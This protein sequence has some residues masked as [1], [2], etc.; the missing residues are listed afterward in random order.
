MRMS[1]LILTVVAAAW[2]AHVLAADVYVCKTNGK[3]MYSDK[4]C[5][6][7]QIVRSFDDNPAPAPG[8]I[9]DISEHIAWSADIR[10]TLHKVAAPTEQATI[11]RAPLR[12]SANPPKMKANYEPGV[13]PPE[14][15][16]TQGMESGIKV[17]AS[18]CGGA[19]CR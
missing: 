19:Y 5:G 12:Q 2:S 7:N 11:E 10:Q 1:K 15:S 13:G 17:A 14:K 16:G 18:A 4:P 9:R 8:Q 3:V 6:V